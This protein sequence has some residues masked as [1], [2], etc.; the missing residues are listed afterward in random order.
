MFEDESLIDFSSS[1]LIWN[2]FWIPA[3]DLLSADIFSRPLN[4][5]S[6]YLIDLSEGYLQFVC[7]SMM[8]QV[9][10][11]SSLYT[12]TVPPINSMRDLQMLKPRP[13][14]VLFSPACSSNLLKFI[15]SFFWFSAE[16]P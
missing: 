9:P 10:L 1:I 3:D 15:K 4:F 5:S 8:K 14:P 12:L 7:S 13:V 16:I 6:H 2:A 11:P